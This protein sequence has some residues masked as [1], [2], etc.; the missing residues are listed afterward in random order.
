M[1]D[2]IL[3][4]AP[5]FVENFKEQFDLNF[6]QKDRWKY[7][8]TGLG[9]TLKITAIAAI[10]GIVIGV[11]IAAVRTSYDKK[12]GIPQ[13][14]WRIHLVYYEISQ[15]HLQNLPHRHQRYTCCSSAPYHIFHHIC[16]IIKRRRSCHICIWYQLR[17]VCCGNLPWR[18]YVD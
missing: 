15:F 5:A 17:C 13:N 18:Y 14:S 6:I 9:N 10:I 11:L 1:L 8:V 4:K 16:I 3:M 12:R 7:M 2:I